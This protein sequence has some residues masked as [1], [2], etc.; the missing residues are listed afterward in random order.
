M[1]VAAPMSARGLWLN[2][3]YKNDAEIVVALADALK[4]EYKAIVDA[5]F[6]LQLDDAFMAHEYA[7]LLGEMSARDVHKYAESC[8]ELTNHALSGIPEDKVRYHVCWG[9]W[10]VPHVQDV[11]LKTIVR[12]DS[13]S[14][15]RRPMRSKRQSA[16]CPRIRWSGRT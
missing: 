11:P 5:G 12:S 7:R 1:P 16:S 4:E 14:A 13:E 8:V 15:C 2:T 9:S 10:N 3:Y 6:I